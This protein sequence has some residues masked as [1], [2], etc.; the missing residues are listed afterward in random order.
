MGELPTAMQIAIAATTVLIIEWVMAASATLTAV[1]I[2]PIATFTRPMAEASPQACRLQLVMDS[3]DMDLD[4]T[5]ALTTA[6]AACM[7]TRFTDTILTDTT[8]TMVPVL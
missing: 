6:W 4:F 3:E 1:S 8:I 5:M 2:L 7:E